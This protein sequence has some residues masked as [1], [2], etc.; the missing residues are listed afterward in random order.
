MPPGI[1]RN[2]F[3]LLKSLSCQLVVGFDEANRPGPL[4]NPDW[5]GAG[6]TMLVAIGSSTPITSCGADAF[7]IPR[8]QKIGDYA[9]LIRHKLATFQIASA[10][11]AE[12][13]R[14]SNRAM[15]RHPATRREY[16][17]AAKDCDRRTAIKISNAQPPNNIKFLPASYVLDR[18]H[19]QA[20]RNAPQPIAPKKIRVLR[21]CGVC[22]DQ[23]KLLPRRS[24]A[25]DSAAPAGPAQASAR[26]VNAFRFFRLIRAES[27]L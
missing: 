24:P 2:N 23:T 27:F 21:K 25:D 6:R 7:F 14:P 10:V 15:I 26:Y 8:R 13:S 18:D 20:V 1:R 19:E 4:L 16:H 9:G 12:V 11:A 17:T 5:C 3:I 22:P